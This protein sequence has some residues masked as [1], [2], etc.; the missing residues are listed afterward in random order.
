MLCNDNLEKLDQLFHIDSPFLP[1]IKSQYE[2]MRKQ[3]EMSIDIES[4]EL[5][6]KQDD[7][8][9]VR[10][11]ILFEGVREGNSKKSR[12]GNLH[13]LTRKEEG[14]WKIHSTIGLS[15]SGA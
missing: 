12:T 9:V 14:E 2:S 11:N 5:V 4:I 7:L 1:G 8:L 6:A 10:D 3:L 15:M 13:V